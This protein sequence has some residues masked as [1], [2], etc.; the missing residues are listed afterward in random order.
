MI[1]LFQRVTVKRIKQ[2][3]K[4]INTHSSI[5]SLTVLKL[6]ERHLQVRQRGQVLVVAVIGRAQLGR[7]LVPLLLQQVILGLQ[8]F[9]VLIRANADDDSKQEPR[10]MSQLIVSSF[11]FL[12]L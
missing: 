2:T 5:T 12:A 3:L 7:Q 9:G 4:Q 6:L 10:K 11:F 8:R 1:L